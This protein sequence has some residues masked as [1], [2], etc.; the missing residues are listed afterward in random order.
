[1]PCMTMLTSKT[2]G[3]R[4]VRCANLDNPLIIILKKQLKNSMGAERSVDGA[5]TP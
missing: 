5:G 4:G 2:F 3:T 1:M